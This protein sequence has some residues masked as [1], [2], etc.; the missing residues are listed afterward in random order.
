[1][2]MLDAQMT[3]GSVEVLGTSTQVTIERS[4][5]LQPMLEYTFEVRAE[6]QDGR[7]GVETKVTTYLGKQIL[8]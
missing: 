8:S 5:G 6:S 3:T 4:D 2:S 1:M 7:L